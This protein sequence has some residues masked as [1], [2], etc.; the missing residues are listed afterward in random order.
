[1]MTTPTP[2]SPVLPMLCSQVEYADDADIGTGG[3]GQPMPD[4]YEDD[5]DELEYADDAD[6]G[7]GGEPEWGGGGGGGEEG[8][9]GEGADGLDG[10]GWLAGLAGDFLGGGAPEEVEEPE[11]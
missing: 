2:L 4:V 8:G 10:G 5:D 9:G 3:E 1:M 6:V 7:T 11:S